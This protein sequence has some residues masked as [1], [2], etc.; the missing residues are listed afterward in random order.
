MCQVFSLRGLQSNQLF[1][2]KFRSA[3]L[4]PEH[5]FGNLALKK[6]AKFGRLPNSSLDDCQ[7]LVWT[8]ANIN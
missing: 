1:R 3:K 4:L 8:T 7:T 5:Q 6:T 2:Q